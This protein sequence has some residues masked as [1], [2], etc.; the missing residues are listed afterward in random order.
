MKTTLE[1]DDDLLVEAKVVAARRRTTL[2]A[3]VEHALRRE[4][5]PVV[6]GKSDPAVSGL[7]LLPKTGTTN[8]NAELHRRLS[9]GDVEDAIAWLESAPRKTTRRA[10]R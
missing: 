5:S 8:P 6:D 1:I 2:R 4:L 7:P 3:I 10:A 9:S